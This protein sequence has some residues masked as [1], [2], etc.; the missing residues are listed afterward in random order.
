MSHEWH[1]QTSQFETDHVAGWK[2]AALGLK[3]HFAGCLGRSMRQVARDLCRIGGDD[4]DTD[5]RARQIEGAIPNLVLPFDRQ[6]IG[7]TQLPLAGW[8]RDGGQ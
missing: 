4:T 8:P 6:D 3:D 5:I 2:R 7:E 1:V